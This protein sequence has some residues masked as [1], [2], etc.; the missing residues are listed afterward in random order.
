MKFCPFLIQ[1]IDEAIVTACNLYDKRL[2]AIVGTVTLEEEVKQSVNESSSSTTTKVS[3]IYQEAFVPLDY[4]ALL[5]QSRERITLKIS[6]DSLQ[7]ATTTQKELITQYQVLSSGKDNHSDDKNNESTQ[8]IEARVDIITLHRLL[9]PPSFEDEEGTGYHF[10]QLVWESNWFDLLGA[11]FPLTVAGKRAFVDQFTPGQA[12]K[13]IPNS[14][15]GK[16]AEDGQLY[17]YQRHL[18]FLSISGWKALRYDSHITDR[19]HYSYSCVLE[20]Y[21]WRLHNEETGEVDR[22]KV[23]RDRYSALLSSARGGGDL[24]MF[25]YPFLTH[26][27]QVLLELKLFPFVAKLLLFLLEEFK[28]NRLRPLVDGMAV[29]EKTLKQ[30]CF[31]FGGNE[32]NLTSEQLNFP[33]SHVPEYEGS[34][35]HPKY[36]ISLFDHV[37]FPMVKNY[38]GAEGN[39]FDTNGDVER[40]SKRRAA[41]DA[42]DSE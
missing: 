7:K 3:S 1:S 36:N 42:S 21:G 15:E 38:N 37:W 35:S 23:W 14:Q 29:D 24:K 30:L 34:S 31:D 11:L 25:C 2:T 19:F 39:C 16:E 9:K 6:F 8:D 41:L 27:M 10:A 22:N 12:A 33:S 40:I 32:T 28:A 18:S 5:Y 13:D 20:Y 4:S 26:V 17:H